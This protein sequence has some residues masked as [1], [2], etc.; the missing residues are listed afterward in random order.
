MSAPSGFSRTDVARCWAG[1]ASFGT[2]LVHVAV[3]REH[4]EV[5]VAHGIFFTVVGLSQ[6][7]WGLWAL[8]RPTVPLPRLTAAATLGLMALWAVSR[9]VGLSLDPNTAR[10]E[11]VGTP[12]LLA[13][14]LEIALVL[15]IL[16]AAQRPATAHPLDERPYDDLPY[17]ADGDHPRTA[18]ASLRV[19]A[20]LAAGALAVS[21][22]ATPAMAASMA[23]DYAHEHGH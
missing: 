23:G 21:A 20:L 3:M 16:V 11:P 12:D 5:S 17:G 4:L 19:L 2:G 13:V 15:C 10:P 6:L 18:A 9:T 7:G 1:F 14:V 22:V 8:A